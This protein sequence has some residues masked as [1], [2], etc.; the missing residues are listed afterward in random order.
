MNRYALALGSNLGDR[1]ANLR[2]AVRQLDRLGEI[3][4]RS[5]VYETDPV[6]GPE[7]EPYLNAVVLL[8]TPLEPEEMLEHCL[9]IEAEGGRLR[10]ERWGPRTIDIDVIVWDGGRLETDILQVPHPR[11]H[12]RAFVLYPLVEVWPDA[13]LAGERTASELKDSVGA[14][15][16]EVVHSDW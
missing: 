12:L 6:G 13:T 15:G 4:E 7:Q 5:G 1:M 16:I 2:R 14:V 9:R 10:H 11:A 3:Q 8:D